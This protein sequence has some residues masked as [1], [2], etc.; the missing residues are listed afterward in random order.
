MLAPAILALVAVGAI[1]YRG[2]QEDLLVALAF[3]IVGYLLRKHGWPRVPF[4]I[5][6]VLG[7]VVEHNLQLSMRLV[8]LGRLSL[9]DR[10]VALVIL[11]L[12][13]LTLVWVLLQKHH[14]VET[15]T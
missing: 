13:V 5:A 6:F 1:A 12:I 4:V 2:R 15:E 9:W 8:S 14:A 7:E 11:A 10:P 3:G